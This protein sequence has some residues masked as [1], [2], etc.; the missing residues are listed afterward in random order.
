MRRGRL[1]RRPALLFIRRG[2]RQ[3]RCRARVLRL[4]LGHPHVQEIGRIAPAS[5][6]RFLPTRLL[7]E[8]DAPYLAP[9]PHR[10]GPNEPAYVVH[11]ARVLGEVVGISGRGYGRASTTAN[12]YRLF[13]KA[14]SAEAPTGPRRHEP[15][16]HH[17]RLRVVGRRAA[18][19]LGMGRL[20]S[21]K[22]E[23]SPAALFDPGRADRRALGKTSVLVDTSPDLREQLLDAD[24][25]RLDA[26]L[27]THEHADHTHGIDDLRPLVIHMRR[28]IP[29]YADACHQRD[30]RRRFGYCFQRRRAANIRRSST[31][32]RI[33]AAC[34]S[35]STAPAG[36]VTGVPFRM[37]HGDIDALGFRFGDLAYAPRCQRRAGRDLAGA[38]RT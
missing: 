30:A 19:R 24:V 34:R 22:P 33:A 11:T 31:E 26:V 2:A 28:R 5:P 13:A 32:H 4:L 35:R 18:R 27:F 8:T 16:R 23:E 37:L 9:E 12:F 7:V 15:A 6:P 29:I 25:M 17:P 3:D 10:G 14:A 36:A 38:A 1:R 20:R 21:A